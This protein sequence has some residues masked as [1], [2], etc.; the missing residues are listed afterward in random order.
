MKIEWRNHTLLGR[1]AA[2]APLVVDTDDDPRDL[3]FRPADAAGARTLTAG[4]VERFNTDGLLGAL[5]VFGRDEVSAIG[6][7][8]EDLVRTVVEAPDRRNAYSIINYHGV[9]RGL[10]DIT[11]T[12]AILDY[13]QDILGPD[14]VCWNTHLFCKPPGD[15]KEVPFHQDCVYWPLSPSATV[16]FWLALDDVDEGNAPMRYTPGSHLAGPL[17]HRQLEL[18]GTR[19]LKREVAAAPD[20]GAILM[21]VLAAG[22]ASIHADLLL[23]G[24]AANISGRRRSALAIRYASTDIRPIEGAEWYLSTTVPGRGVVPD[25]L[26]LRRRPTSEHPEL[27]ANVWGDFDGN[28]S[29]AD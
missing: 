17:A 5:P 3:R 25:R 10:Y 24:S 23:H 22:E 20:D 16:T 18:D 6:D 12:P 29:R 26:R 2:A 7:Y 9:C 28:V 4:Q 13:V 1:D 8:V 19:T 21:N 27:M 11:Q 15:P 14:F